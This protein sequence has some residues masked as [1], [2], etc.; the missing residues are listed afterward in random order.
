MGAMARVATRNSARR[1]WPQ[2]AKPLG[3]MARCLGSKE[4]QPSGELPSLL[5][6]QLGA[7]V[8]KQPMHSLRISLCL[9]VAC[10]TAGARAAPPAHVQCA[11][12]P[13]RIPEMT[14]EAFCKLQYNA[15]RCSAYDEQLIACINRKGGEGVGGGCW[16]LMFR[17]PDNIPIREAEI[18][19]P[20][21]TVR[22]WPG[23]LQPTLGTQNHRGYA[24]P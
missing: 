7:V 2:A 9:A 11:L 16:H 19:R 24:R 6:T 23:I 18:C 15:A 17:R 13:S 20:I 1:L 14:H 4:A 3:A 8:L 21:V 5:T 22:M 10:M 12:N